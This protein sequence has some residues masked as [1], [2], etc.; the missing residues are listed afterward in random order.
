MSKKIMYMSKNYTN[1]NCK[2]ISKLTRLSKN[3]FNRGFPKLTYSIDLMLQIIYILL[4]STQFSID[5]SFCFDI[6]IA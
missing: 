6:N 3:S 2:I 4:C 1:C 5:E